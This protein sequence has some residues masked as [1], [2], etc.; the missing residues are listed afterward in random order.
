M[1]RHINFQWTF[2]GVNL[3]VE[4]LNTMSKN[5]LYESISQSRDCSW[6]HNVLKPNGRRLNSRNPTKRPHIFSVCGYK[7]HSWNLFSLF[8]IKTNIFSVLRRQFGN[9]SFREVFIDMKSKREE[10]IGNFWKAQNALR[11]KQWEFKCGTETKR[12]SALVVR[13][14]SQGVLPTG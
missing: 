1:S 5:R 12:R 9:K 11:L 4:S 10:H 2:L 14:T 13:G 3:G 6:I 7:F 8:F